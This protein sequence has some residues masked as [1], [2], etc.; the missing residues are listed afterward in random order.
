MMLKNMFWK[1]VKCTTPQEFEWIMRQMEAMKPQAT[2]DFQVVGVQKFCRAFISTWTTSPT[3]DNNV[4]ESFNNY[5]LQSR[6]M[7]IIDMLEYIRSA[8]MHRIVRKRNKISGSSDEL[9]PKIRKLLNKIILSSRKCTAKDA[10]DFK[11]EVRTLGNQFVV[12]L[13]ARTCGCK[14]WD[15]TGIPCPHTVSCIHCENWDPTYFVFDWFKREKYRDAY[16]RSITPMDSKIVW[17]YNKCNYLFPPLVRRQPGR[18][19]QKRRVDNSEI[20]PT[21]PSSSKKGMRMTCRI[22]GQTGHNRKKCTQRRVVHVIGVSIRI[23]N[24]LFPAFQVY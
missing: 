24:K 8:I 3:T 18:P 16:S 9:C 13:R 15:V 20:E 22:F 4:F 11:Y 6:S 21:R 7:P 5:I 14:Y 17:R 1:A 12:D 23:S 19:K 2:H 10:G